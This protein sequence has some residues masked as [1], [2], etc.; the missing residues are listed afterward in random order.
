MNQQPIAR[1]DSV[2]QVLHWL[3]AIIVLIAFIYGPGGPEHR[4]YSAARDFD[5][6]LHETLGVCVF[7]LVL[8]RIGWKFFYTKPEPPS[9]PRWMSIAAAS[10]Q[11]ILMLLMLALPI[12][13]IT[14]A[15]LEGHPVTLLAGIEIPPALNTAHDLGRTIANIHGWL[16][17]AIIWIAGFHAVA[18]IYHH[19]YRKDDILVSMLPRWI[20]GRLLGR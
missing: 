6:Q 9:M 16:G 1:Y 18:A 3:T 15:W 4:I 10:V 8:I 12:T 11:G 7:V 13:A 14:G 20:T 5:R 17:D 19:F 2:T